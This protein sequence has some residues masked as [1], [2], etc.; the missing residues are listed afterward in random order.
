MQDFLTLKERQRLG[1]NRGLLILSAIIYVTSSL[2]ANHDTTVNEAWAR[3]K[4]I[5]MFDFILVFIVL[6][7][8]VIKLVSIYGYKI[9]LYTLIN[10]Y[11]DNYFGLKGW[12]LNDFL[13][14]VLIIF[15]LPIHKI[16]EKYGKN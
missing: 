12:S 10:Y 6:R 11:I 5:L 9:I 16:K 13:T 15:E 3:W 4:Y 8:E 7:K 1:L 14:I 2:V